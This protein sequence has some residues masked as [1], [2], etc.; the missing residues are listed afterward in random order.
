MSR[1]RQSLDRAKRA[2]RDGGRILFRGATIISMDADVGDLPK[3]DLLIEGRK[4][5]AVGPDLAAAGADAQA[6]EVD[7]GGTILLPGFVD[8]HRHSWQSQFRRLVPDVAFP[9]YLELMHMRLG[10]AYEPEDMYL[11]NL[12]AATGAIDSGVTSVL[13]FAHNVRSAEYSDEG[14]RAWRDAGVRAVFASCLPLSG[15]FDGW[16]DDLTRLRTEQFS[17]NEGLLTL[18]MGVG[19]RAFPGVEGDICLSGSG[20]RHARDL[21]IG[22][23]V[24]AVLGEMAGEHIVELGG[25]RVLGPDITWIHCSAIGDEA[26]STLVESG[27]QVVLATTS[28][29]QMM[30]AGGLAPIQ[31]TIDE[32]LLPALSVDVE[33]SLTT[34]MFSQMQ[35]TLQTQRLMVAQAESQRIDAPAPISTRDV[36]RYATEGGARANG[37]WDRCGSL[38]PGKRADLILIDAGAVNNFPLNNAVGTVVLGSDS[39]NVDTVIIDGVPRK[40]GGELVDVDLGKLRDAV[41]ESRDRLL[42]RIGFELNLV[43]AGTGLE[44]AAH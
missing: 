24:D 32:G 31:R 42:D 30:Q 39:R 5:L 12:L 23:T 7:A 36:L 3:G 8:G 41:T 2:N 13:D 9:G 37:I 17:S 25:Q 16:R 4:I 20:I 43:A 22:V 44:A 35:A 14:I 38:T 11:G 34:N 10:P 29:Q 15:K 27:A 26:W 18:R 28:D 19:A 6:A 21:D 1:D 33:C 40:W